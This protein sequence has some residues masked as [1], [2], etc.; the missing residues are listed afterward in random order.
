MRACA[1]GRDRTCSNVQAAGT[2][3]AATYKQLGQYVQQRTRSWDR[4]CSNVQA[5]GAVRAA[6]YKQLGPYVQQRTSSWD[7][8]P[9]ACASVLCESLLRRLCKPTRN[10]ITTQQVP[11]W[12]PVRPGTRGS[13]VILWAVGDTPWAPSW[14]CS[15]R[16]H[17]ILRRRASG[18]RR[19]GG[20]HRQAEQTVGGRH[21]TARLWK[22][23]PAAETLLRNKSAACPDEQG[24]RCLWLLSALK[25]LQPA[26][27]LHRHRM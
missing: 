17:W 21:C 14:R 25:L 15:E 19:R 10:H 8:L 4:T 16:S 1:T 18:R 2:V 27:A 24:G 20:G 11:A 22:P 23:P 6:T 12:S 26:M 5:A 13:N 7:Q 3:R 9:A